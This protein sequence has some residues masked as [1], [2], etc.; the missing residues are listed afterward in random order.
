M[1]NQYLSLKGEDEL[2]SFM[3]EYGSFHD[4]CISK[5]TIIT[6]YSVNEELN[7][8]VPMNFATCVSI[9]IEKQK[10]KYRLIELLFEEVIHLNFVP[11]QEN[12]DR[13]IYDAYF[14]YNAGLVFWADDGDWNPENI[15]N[16]ICWISAKKCSWRNL[17]IAST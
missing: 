10:Y 7:M 15:D 12:Y 16:S 14:K 4:S 11:A 17:T 2:N 6:G 9:T 3:K 8:T 13:I 5:C 1:D